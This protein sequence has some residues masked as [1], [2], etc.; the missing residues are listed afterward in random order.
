MIS[1][2]PTAAGKLPLH[3]AY[4]GVVVTMR[5][6]GEVEAEDRDA[7]STADGR[8]L[9]EEGRVEEVRE[10]EQDAVGDRSWAVEVVVVPAAED[11]GTLAL[12]ECRWTSEVECRFWRGRFP[13]ASPH[14]VVV[15]L[16]GAS[17][18]AKSLS[19][20]E[21]EEAEEEVEVEV[22]VDVNEPVHKRA[23]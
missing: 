14:S 10:H 22:A 20:H 18:N 3:C 2:D 17:Q 5:K 23:V 1:E 4:P 15:L 11:G 6:D 12:G 8:H 21:A 13:C 7:E 19:L 16:V 9:S